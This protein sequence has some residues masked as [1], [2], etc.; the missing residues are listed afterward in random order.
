MQYSVQYTYMDSKYI[1][2]YILQMYHQTW[3]RKASKRQSVNINNDV[4]K[5]EKD[6]NRDMSYAVERYKI[7]RNILCRKLEVR[8]LK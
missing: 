4:N 7:V 3:A 5:L 1:S 6:A 8:N 2:M